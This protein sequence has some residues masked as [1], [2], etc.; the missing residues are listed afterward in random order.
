MESSSFL[1]G[2]MVCEIIVVTLFYL[3]K[4]IFFPSIPWWVVLSPVWLPIILVIVT[5]L[6]LSLFAIVSVMFTNHKHR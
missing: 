1:K 6:L 5:I 2:L 4:K 3:I